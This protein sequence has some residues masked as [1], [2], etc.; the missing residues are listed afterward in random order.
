MIEAAR[1]FSVDGERVYVWENRTILSSG[2]GEFSEEF[3]MAT[4]IFPAISGCTFDVELPI[5]IIVQRNVVIK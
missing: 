1:K 4:L 5:T 3:S 2:R